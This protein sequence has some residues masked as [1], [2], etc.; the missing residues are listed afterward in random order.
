MSEFSIP[1]IRRITSHTFF[2]SIIRS[3]WRTFTFFSFWI[4]KDTFWANYFFSNTFVKSLII[5]SP[6]ITLEAGFSNMIKMI[7]TRTEIAMSRTLNGVRLRTNT[8]FLSFIIYFIWRARFTFSWWLVPK[9]NIIANNT[10]FCHFRKM[11][12]WLTCSTDTILTNRMAW[13]T[14]FANIFILLVYWILWAGDATFNCW[15]IML[16]IWTTFALLCCKIP[17]MRCRTWN[18]F[19]FFWTIVGIFRAWNAFKIIDNWFSERALHTL[20]FTI[21]Y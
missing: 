3:L 4:K 12:S 17:E 6:L 16:I 21:Q 19:L 14:S 15:V 10:L 5:M 8:N 20:I 9:L 1:K 2:P 11:T 18:T 13:R 7:S